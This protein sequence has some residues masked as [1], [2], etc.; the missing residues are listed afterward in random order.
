MSEIINNREYRR[1]TLRKLINRLHDG[2]SVD[3]VKEDFQRLLNGVTTEEIA[4]LEN[5]LVSEGMPVEE[6]QRLCDVHAAVLGSSVEQIHDLKKPVEEEGHPI[7]VFKAENRG[8]E[9]FIESSLKPAMAAFKEEGSEDN[10]NKLLNEVQKLLEI[11]KHYSRKEN[12]LFPYMEKYDITTPPQVMWGVDDEIRAEIKEA[13]NNIKNKTDMKNI[14]KDLENVIARVNDMIFK[15]ENIL[16]P[17]V[18]DLLTEDEWVTIDKESH[19]I[20]FVSLID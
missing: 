19:E 6:I 14:L 17:M 11:D 10:T 8:I 12:L 9:D 5:S 2:E 7:Y 3:V 18:E 15:E 1:E 4:E 13:I 20:G 16:F